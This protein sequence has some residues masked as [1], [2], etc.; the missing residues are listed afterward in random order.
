M[1]LRAL[2]VSNSDLDTAN[3]LQVVGLVF[4]FSS[5]F[6]VFAFLSGSRGIANARKYST[7]FLRSLAPE[8][9]VVSS[10]SATLLA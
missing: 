5:L 2:R 10:Q 3:I 8:R 4:Y 7:K 1:R 6:L 9:E